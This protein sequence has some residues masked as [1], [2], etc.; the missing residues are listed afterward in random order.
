MK[1]EKMRRAQTMLTY[2]TEFFSVEGSSEARSTQGRDSVAAGFRKYKA[3]I[4]FKKSS[5]MFFF[6]AGCRDV[7][8]REE[9]TSTM[10]CCILFDEEVRMVENSSSQSSVVSFVS[11]KTKERATVDLNALRLTHDVLES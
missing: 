5:H 3:S 7:A 1:E 9:F 4:E 8:N 11:V 10:S 2:K 6:W